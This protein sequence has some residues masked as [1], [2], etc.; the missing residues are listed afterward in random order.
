MR[1]SNRTE[2]ALLALVFLAKQDK[3]DYVH[4]QEIARAQ[5]I[6]M[7]F[8]Q[9]ILLSLKQARIVKSIKGKSG[10]YALARDSSTISLA[11]VVRLFDG[12]LAPTHSV[13]KFYPEETPILAEKKVVRLLKEIRDYIANKLENTFLSDIV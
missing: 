3:G 4:G 9:Q 6:P 1:L 11:E 12:L 7:R 13:S 5:D 8:L 2:Y 10:G